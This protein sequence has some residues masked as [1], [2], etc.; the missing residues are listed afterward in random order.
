MLLAALCLLSATFTDALV[1]GSKLPVTR[2]IRTS[3]PMAGL[4]EELL[5]GMRKGFDAPVVMGTEEM[6]SKKAYG[7]SAVPIQT[8]LRWGCDVK[9]ADNICNYNRHYAEYSGYWERA[10][11]FLAEE[12]KSSEELTFFDSNT[13]K[14]LFYGPKNRSWDAF[15]RESKSHG[16]PSF[17]DAEVNWDYVR[18]LP[19]GECISVDGTHLGHN[20]PDSSGNRYCINLVSVAGKPL[21]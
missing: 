4:L 9:T 15:I 2:A 8:D 21:A 18:V 5:G 20:L 10:T 16:W 12:S 14:P 6:M 19:N 13:G 1:I 3:S 17:R 7:T 11:S